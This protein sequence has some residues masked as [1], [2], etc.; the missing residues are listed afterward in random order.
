M[1]TPTPQPIKPPVQPVKSVAAQEEPNTVKL[2]KK[3]DDAT[4]KFIKLE[5]NE[6]VGTGKKMDMSIDWTCFRCGRSNASYVTTCACGVTKRRAARV[7]ETG[8]DPYAVQEEEDKKKK[9][10]RDKAMEAIYEQKSNYG[11]KMFDSNVV[12]EVETVSRQ[13]PLERK[14]TNMFYNMVEKAGSKTNTPEKEDR[15]SKYAQDQGV[16]ANNQQTASSPKRI[17]DPIPTPPPIQADDDDMPKKWRPSTTKAA[18]KPA[19]TAAKEPAAQK[20]ADAAVERQPHFDEWKCP[21]CGTINND[22]VSTCSCGCSQRRAKR[23]NAGESPAAARAPQKPVSKAPAVPPKRDIPPSPVRNAAQ[24]NM[25][26]VPLPNEKPTA[27]VPSTVMSVT[28]DVNKKNNDREPYFDEWKCPDCGMINNDYV[29][30]C[31]CGCSQRRAK[32]LQKKK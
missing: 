9:E 25:H 32:R 26:N 5:P 12:V 22:Y 31:S 19:S 15:L 1:K 21:D 4:E 11:P 7:Y 20:A 14:M 17:P 13:S 10:E 3:D 6:W 8:V 18:E 27:A 16:A 29:M 30:T 23:M 2:G 24:Q 28:P